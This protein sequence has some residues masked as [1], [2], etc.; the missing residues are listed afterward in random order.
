MKTQGQRRLEVIAFLEQYDRDGDY[1]DD[2]TAAQGVPPLTL[3]DALKLCVLQLA[4]P[5]VDDP[6]VA[7]QWLT[8]LDEFHGGGFHPDTPFTD[9]VGDDDQPTY[10]PE[11]AAMLQQ[12]FNI[13]ADAMNVYEVL[14]PLMEKRMQAR[15]DN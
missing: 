6:E 1:S 13:V 10:T 4:E 11:E 9:Y 5:A 2:A 15:G 7:K 14:L 8:F 3:A 12:C